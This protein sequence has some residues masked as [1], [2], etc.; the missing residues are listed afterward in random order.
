MAAD[1]NT[2]AK[3]LLDWY[4]QRQDMT[5]KYVEAYRRYCW[6]VHALDDLKLA[7]F[8]FLA[9]EGYLHTDKD[10]VWHMKMAARLAEAE[11]GT[12]YCDTF[13][14]SGLER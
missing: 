14:D 9:S 3:P 7:P 8:H 10:H 2:D 1:R 11:S 4:H 5:G 13:Q 6:P 12:H